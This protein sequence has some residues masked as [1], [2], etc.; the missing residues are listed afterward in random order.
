MRMQSLVVPEENGKPQELL[1]AKS[2]FLKFVSSKNLGISTIHPRGTVLFA[3]GEDARGVYLLLSGSVKV[4]LT[5]AQGKILII[6]IAKPGDLLG[7]NSTMT[8]N[9]YEATAE[10]ANYCRAIFIP[11]REFGSLYNHNEDVK[12]FVLD[13]FSRQMSEMIDS[14]RRLLL[15]ETAEEKLAG[16]I[17]KWC[18]EMGSFESEGVRVFHSFTQEEIGQMICASRETVSRLLKE[19][20]R[21]KL[22]TISTNSILVHNL[23]ALE[24]IEKEVAYSV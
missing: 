10:T 4:S 23:R 17:I 12:E 8:R 18:R 3:E 11:L 14:S 5:S 7:I 9:P 24:N 22:M 13:S 15:S 6:R 21:R 16:L 20:V 2:Q 1:F 19:F